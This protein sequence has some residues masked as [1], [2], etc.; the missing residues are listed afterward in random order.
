MSNS[1]FNV[2][3]DQADIDTQIES[4]GVAAMFHVDAANDVIGIGGV[5]S[6]NVERL[7]IQGTESGTRTVRIST[8]A[9]VA[10]KGVNG[11][12]FDLRR[13]NSDDVGQVNS[14]LGIMRWIGEDS[15]SNDTVYAYI[16]A[17]IYDPTNGSEDGVLK[18]NIMDGGTGTEYVRL[19]ARDAASPDFKGVIINETSA[20]VSFRVESDGVNPAFM[21]DA[22][23][24][25]VGIGTAPDSG[26]E[27][28]HIKGTD[29]GVLI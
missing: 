4:T 19:T 5:A 3:A 11:P 16:A 14:N 18:F 9:P 20:D 7:D 23:L 6:S 29:A 22:A 21:V 2:N 26:V 25:S 27:R 15:A 8:N 13:T 17:E 28:L 10:E 1:I 24:D 12:Y